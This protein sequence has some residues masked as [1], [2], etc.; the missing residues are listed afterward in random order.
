MVQVIL[1]LGFFILLAFVVKSI[2]D[3]RTKQQLIKK[4]MVGEEAKHMLQPESP[5]MR[6]LGSLRWAM[7]LIGIGVAIVLGRLVPARMS[8]EVTLGGIFFFAGLGFLVYYLLAMR[9]TKDNGS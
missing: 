4:D 5:R 2:L 7:V 1:L 9:I 3:H 8:E 6:V